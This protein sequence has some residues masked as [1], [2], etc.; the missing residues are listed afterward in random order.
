[1][2]EEQ[3]RAR[4]ILIEANL[5][6][7]VPAKIDYATWL[8]DQPDDWQDRILGRE[9]AARFRAGDLVVERYTDP[10][11]VAFTLEDLAAGADVGRTD[12]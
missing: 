12:D 8:R 9:K 10:P 11:S 6:P 5:G 2:T 4:R 7:E 1:M 3:K